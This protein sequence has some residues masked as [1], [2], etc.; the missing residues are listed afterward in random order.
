VGCVG[1]GGLGGG[2][3]GA[4]GGILATDAGGTLWCVYGDVTH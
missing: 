4:V 1:W 2:R 3:G